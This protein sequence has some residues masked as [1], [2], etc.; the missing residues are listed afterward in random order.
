MSLLN[1]SLFYQTDVT[2][3]SYENLDCDPVRHLIFKISPDVFQDIQIYPTQP[4]VGSNKPLQF[5]PTIA[6]LQIQF[7]FCIILP[8]GAE[9]T[10]KATKYLGN[11]ICKK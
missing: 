1:S 10:F 9:N 4:M 3:L 8:K 2:Q 7:I 6:S 5:Q 11:V